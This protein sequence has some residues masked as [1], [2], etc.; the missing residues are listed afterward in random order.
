MEN[1]I[2]IDFEAIAFKIYRK[3]NSLG[4]VFIIVENEL[5]KSTCTYRVL[6]K[7]S[8]FNETVPPETQTHGWLNGWIKQRNN[9]LEHF[10]LISK[11]MELFIL[12]RNL[13]EYFG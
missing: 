6:D 7:Y 12:E 4:G 3:S 8:W 2:E 13:R 5:I 9:Y 1:K 11:S 10:G